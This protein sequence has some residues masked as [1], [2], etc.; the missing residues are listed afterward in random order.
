MCK[1]GLGLQTSKTYG[2]NHRQGVL[3]GDEEIVGVA[4]DSSRPSLRNWRVKI[5]RRP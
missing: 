4:N 5:P 1:T 3:S 2:S